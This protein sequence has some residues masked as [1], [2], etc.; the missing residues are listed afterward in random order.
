MFIFLFFVGWFL[1]GFLT[2]CF[3]F[4]FNI[5]DTI[6]GDGKPLIRSQDIFWFVILFGPVSIFPVICCLVNYKSF[7]ISTKIFESTKYFCEK[8]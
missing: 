8:K 7:D 6:E 1:T 3:C 2:N 5:I 4:Y